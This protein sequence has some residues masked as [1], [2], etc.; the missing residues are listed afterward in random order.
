[1][2]TLLGSLVAEQ[3][4]P[5]IEDAVAGASNYFKQRQVQGMSAFDLAKLVKGGRYKPTV[6]DEG[7]NF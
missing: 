4:V 6:I 1:M 3:L 5:K 2:A 7:G